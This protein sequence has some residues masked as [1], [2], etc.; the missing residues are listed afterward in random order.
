MKAGKKIS[1]KE[2]E[3]NKRTQA[4]KNMYFNRYLFCRYALALF[5]FVNF[6]LAVLMPT[7]LFGM[8]AI[9]LTVLA[10]AAMVESGTQYSKKDRYCKFMALFFIVQA[11]YNIAMLG[12]LLAM[13]TGEVLPFLKS[14]DDAASFAIVACLIGL[15]CVAFSLFRLY[16]IWHN[17]DKQLQRIQFF[18]KKYNLMVK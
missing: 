12:A 5:F 14:N 13:P 1:R 18:E 6:Y 3:K 15:G 16:Q 10:V 9:L 11:F 7:T 4:I 2:M 17:T 8:G